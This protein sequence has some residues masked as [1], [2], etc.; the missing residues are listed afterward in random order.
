MAMACVIGALGAVFVTANTRIVYALRQRC[1]PH[2]SRYRYLSTFPTNIEGV[3][4]K[5]L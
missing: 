5:L 3:A 1:I 2:S 4:A